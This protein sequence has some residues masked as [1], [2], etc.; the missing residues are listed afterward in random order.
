MWSL[1][2]EERM[3]LGVRTRAKIL[4]ALL[5]TSTLL[6]SHITKQV[7]LLSAKLTSDSEKFQSKVRD[8]P[9][10][11]LCDGKIGLKSYLFLNKLCEDCFRLF[12][13]SDVFSACR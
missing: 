5:L 8:S 11:L 3:V 9:V 10:N 7:R 2:V 12:R 6:S 1:Y 13:S 4:L